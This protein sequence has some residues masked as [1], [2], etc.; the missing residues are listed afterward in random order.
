M[1]TQPPFRT[2]VLGTLAYV[3]ASFFVQAL[4]HFVVNTSH[5]AAIPFLRAEPILALGV[6]TMVLQG[7]LLSYLFP[8]VLRGSTIAGS[9]SGGTTGN[10][11]RTTLRAA[12]GFAWL[13]GLFLG[14]YIALVE[15]SKY[16]APS[17]AS[18]IGVEAS[19]TLVQFTLFGLLLAWVH[20]PRPAR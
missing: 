13:M 16:A 11:A 9:K 14:S 4:S 12:L 2:V 19:A 18:W 7:V 8:L 20:R 3:A 15:P 1:N 6:F 10:T 17:I 5:Y